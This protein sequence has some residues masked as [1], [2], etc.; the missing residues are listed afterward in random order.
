MDCVLLFC[1]VRQHHVA[2]KLKL[3]F[4]KMRDKAPRRFQWVTS[5]INPN[6]DC[7][8]GSVILN[9]VKN[10]GRL[11][12]VMLLCRKEMLRY[13]QHDSLWLRNIGIGS[14]LCLKQQ[15]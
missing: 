11:C 10:L 9:E 3:L 13:A 5:P 6:A 7:L 1:R 2:L 12:P 4:G 15:S 14:V 8:V